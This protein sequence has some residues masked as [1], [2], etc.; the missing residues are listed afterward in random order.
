MK[1]AHTINA[2]A[3]VFGAADLDVEIL[4]LDQ[5]WCWMPS[6]VKGIYYDL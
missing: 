3:P 5:G 4:F 2:Q 1:M 6:A